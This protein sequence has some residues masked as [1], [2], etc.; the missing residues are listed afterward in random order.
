MLT[1]SGLPKL[2]LLLCVA[3]SLFIANSSLNDDFTALLSLRLG[4]IAGPLE[5][6]YSI[7]HW[8][9]D[10]LMA[11]FFLYIGLEI[12]RELVY[13]E[14][15]SLR[16][17]GLPVLAAFGGAIVPAIIYLLFNH[18]TVA[19][20]GWG[21]PIATDI[22]FALTVLSLVG[23]KLP[24]SL[25]IFLTA[26]AIVDDLIAILVI[27]VFYTAE[28]NTDFLFYSGALIGIMI[29]MNR[30]NVRNL[31]LYLLPGLILWYCIHQ[32]GIH[33]TIAG[34]LTALTIPVSK[35]RSASSLEKLEHALVYPINFLIMPVFALA[36]TNIHIETQILRVLA[37]PVGL[38]IILGLTL[39]KPFGI[40]LVSLVAI[41]TRVGS[42]PQRS[43]WIHLA[44]VGMLGG[45]G[46]TMSIFIALLSFGEATLQTEAKLAVLAASAISALAGFIIL[47]TAKKV[48][49]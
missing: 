42:F 21:I 5:L 39:G 22:A 17:A 49:L 2:L 45:I 8:I 32:S 29:V 11:L 26:L 31:W 46:F 47:S 1:K 10:G 37:S 48:E 20:K 7:L 6:Q 44:G 3:A 34:V 23:K 38:G 40:L 18:D 13:G 33:S 36:N 14:L 28:L 25:R 19:S 41:K 43:G 30:L 27:A 15:S 9:N 35:N 12:K 24:A 16:S 4:F